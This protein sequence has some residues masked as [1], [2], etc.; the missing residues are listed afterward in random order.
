MW[1]YTTYNKPLLL[2]IMVLL[3]VFCLF[4]QTFDEMRASYALLLS[5]VLYIFVTGY[6]MTITKDVIN[7]GKGLPE[8]LIKDVVVLGIKTTFVAFVYLFVQGLLF[9]IISVIFHFPIIDFEDL[10]FDF[11]ENVPLLFHH[12]L[13]DTFIFIV[14]V[15]LVFYFTMF[16]IEIAL[17]I[18]ADTGSI[19]DAFNLRNI[20][21]TIDVIG[22]GLYAKHYTVII[23]LLVFFSLL[24]EI[25]TP[26]FVLECISKVFLIFAFFITQYWSIGAIYRIFKRKQSNNLH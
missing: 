15:C 10:L 14:I 22:W 25:D 4:I 5:S 2:I 16:F 8:I 12:N 26:I 20:K 24:I 13:V 9:A 18:L 3:F 21:K 11:F 6:G 1:G 7:G 17:A 19:L 23:L